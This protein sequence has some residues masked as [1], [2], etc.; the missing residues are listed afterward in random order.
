MT[1]DEWKTTNPEDE[2]LGDPD[3]DC[4]CG[5]TYKSR[6]NCAVHGIDPDRAYDEWR[7]RQMEEGWDK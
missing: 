6:R 7:D 2:Y 5:R 3:E 4:T 1:Y